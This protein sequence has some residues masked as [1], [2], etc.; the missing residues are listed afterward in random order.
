MRIGGRPM[1]HG[2]NE[3]IELAM[4]DARPVWPDPQWSLVGPEYPTNQCIHE[5]VENHVK[6]TPDA[7]AVVFE[8]EWLCYRELNRRANRLAHYLIDAG[9]GPEVPVALCLDRSLELAVLVLALSSRP[10]RSACRST[11]TFRVSASRTW[12]K[13]PLPD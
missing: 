11:P 2:S 9:V 3:S 8:D 12:W 1:I 7:V 10:A 4:T 6:G 5:I 13:M